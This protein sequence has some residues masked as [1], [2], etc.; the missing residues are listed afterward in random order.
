FGLVSRFRSPHHLRRES[1][2]RT[3]EP[4]PRQSANDFR[5]NRLRVLALCRGM[6][7]SENRFTLFRIMPY[8]RIEPLGFFPPRLTAEKLMPLGVVI[9]SDP[10]TLAARATPGKE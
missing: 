8:A 5:M 1:F 4:K 7:F 3:S 2:L 9:A 10:S 6:I